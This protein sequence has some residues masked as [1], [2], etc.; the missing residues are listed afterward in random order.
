[1]G[2][3]R[4]TT[5]SSDRTTRRRRRPAR[6][7]SF[8]LR[9]WHLA[10]RALVCSGHQERFAL[11]ASSLLSVTVPTS[12]GVSLHILTWQEIRKWLC[13]QER[14][15]HEFASGRLAHHPLL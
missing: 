2:T 5:S 11:C 12:V 15:E 13:K 3:K 7:G 9:H 1:M 6:V 8:P 14:T 10:L 4:R